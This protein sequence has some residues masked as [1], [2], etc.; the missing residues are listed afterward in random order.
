MEARTESCSCMDESRVKIKM[1]F[2][3]HQ[4]NKYAKKTKEKIGK[5]RTLF[6]QK[7]FCSILSMLWKIRDGVF[8]VLG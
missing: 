7:C 5:A 6:M 4:G 1:S 2:S 3:E 8:K